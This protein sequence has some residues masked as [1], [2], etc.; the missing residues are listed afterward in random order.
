MAIS[1]VHYPF[2][3]ESRRLLKPRLRFGLKHG[4]FG[5]KLS[6]KLRGLSLG[7]FLGL[8]AKLQKL[9]L[10]LGSS[11]LQRRLTDTLRIRKALLC[12]SLRGGDS[13]LGLSFSLC[14][15]RYCFK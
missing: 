11:R 9:T 7:L 13:R 15:A 3:H 12:L 4:F 10:G 2:Y 8:S 5:L 6:R 1:V 14:N